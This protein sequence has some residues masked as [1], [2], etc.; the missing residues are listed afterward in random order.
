MLIDRQT[1]IYIGQTDGCLKKKPGN[2][3]KRQVDIY[4]YK[5]ENVK[6][7]IY[8]FKTHLLFNAAYN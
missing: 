6:T 2:K 1:D 5:A 8:S 3:N 7:I 4:I